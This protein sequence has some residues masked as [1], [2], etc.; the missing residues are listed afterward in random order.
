M[1]VP[2]RVLGYGG[3]PVR[4][5]SRT[6]LAAGGAAPGGDADAVLVLRG[7]APARQPAAQERVAGTS[8]VSDRTRWPDRDRGWPCAVIGHHPRALV[9]AENC[10][11]G[12]RPGLIAGGSHASQADLDA[13]R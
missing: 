8:A 6:A 9:L 11:P 7:I 1:P 2:G 3:R 4:V 12:K 5:A 10:S 13:L